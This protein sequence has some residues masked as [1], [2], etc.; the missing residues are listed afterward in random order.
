MPPPP[1]VLKM[2]FS[3]IQPV[4]HSRELMMLRMIKTMYFLLSETLVGRTTSLSP[5][6][7][8]NAACA[9]V[10]RTAAN[11]GGWRASVA[12]VGLLQP[13]KGITD[14]FSSRVRKD[15]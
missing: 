7:R 12:V 15:G 13:A 3:N 4:P 11:L 10:A 6:E 1:N 14:L 2:T 8:M 5:V 9:I